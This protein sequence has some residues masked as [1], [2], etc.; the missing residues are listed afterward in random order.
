MKNA[1]KPL[2]Y[3]FAEKD[4]HFGL[5]IVLKLHRESLRQMMQHGRVTHLHVV[6]VL[7]ELKSIVCDSFDDH[8]DIKPDNILVD[9]DFDDET[10]TVTNFR[11]YLADFGS[12]GYHHPG[13]TPIYAGPRTYESD[14]KDL[15][16][17]GRLALELFLEPEGN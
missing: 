1:E 14:N 16:S 10:E 5:F 2:A 6:Q 12:S 4:A 13:G 7:E 15:F 11:C 9:Y 17:I 3:F 8:G